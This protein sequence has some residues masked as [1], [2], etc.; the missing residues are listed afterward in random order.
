ML[1]YTLYF[2]DTSILLVH[3]DTY[4][5]CVNMYSDLT[6]LLKNIIIND[7]FTFA[8]KYTYI[9]NDMLMC[10]KTRIYYHLRFHTNGARYNRNLPHNYLRTRSI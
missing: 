3:C 7:L 8:F 1:Q 9:Y 6:L 5:R 2:I 10:L 4:N